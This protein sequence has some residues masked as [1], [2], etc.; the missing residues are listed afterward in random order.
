MSPADGF[1]PGFFDR[2][3]PAADDIF[4]GPPRM[5]TH[6]DDAAIAE[7][8]RLY[9]ELAI[10]GRVLDLMSSWV[11]HLDHHP[12][13]LT[14][15]GMNRA[16][17]EANPMADEVVVHDLNVAPTLPFDDNAFDGALCCVSVDYLTQ[18]IEVFREVRRTLTAGAPFVCTFSNRLFPT[19]AIQGWLTADEATRCEVVAEYFRRSGGW[20]PPVI[21]VRIEPGRGFDPLYAVHAHTER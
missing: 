10:S 20:S 5:V 17:L 2:A 1:P 9:R 3:D 6:I 12:G 8:A 15:L 11:S 16:E 7:V 19:K 21:D 18:P 13:H 4:Y 14:V